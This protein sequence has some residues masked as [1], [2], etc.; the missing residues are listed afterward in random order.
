[1]SDCRPLLVNKKEEETEYSQID[2]VNLD[3]RS[4]SAAGL[5]F[6]HGSKQLNTLWRGM[7]ELQ[8]V[9]RFYIIL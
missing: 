1:M 4:L 5:L 3:Y 8:V 9:S 7:R 2:F 6:T